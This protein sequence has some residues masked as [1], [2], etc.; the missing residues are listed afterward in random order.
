MASALV[1]RPVRLKRGARSQSTASL[2]AE[3][4]RT[5]AHCIAVSALF[6]PSEENECAQAVSDEGSV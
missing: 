3:C 5:L 2:R 1:E 4:I 6:N